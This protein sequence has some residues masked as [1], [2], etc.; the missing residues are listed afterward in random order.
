MIRK[1]RRSTELPL[2][3]L[4]DIFS[5][6]VIYLLVGSHFAPTDIV[7]PK[8]LELP[9]SHSAE[10][11]D[12]AKQVHVSKSVVSIPS[13]NYSVPL[14]AFSQK[15]GSGARVAE[16][17]SQVSRM[18]GTMAPELRQNGVTINFV[19]DKD[20]SYVVIYNVLQ[21]L[22]VREVDNVLFLA[23]GQ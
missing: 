6:L 12:I 2:T 8:D 15:G 11:L 3:A 19:A 22:R 17:Q 7:L 4:V 20:L 18:I 16:F 5:I 14:A 1:K 10:N 23:Q 9:S 13:L 21:A